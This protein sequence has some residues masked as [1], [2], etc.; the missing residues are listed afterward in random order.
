[1]SI[2]A[3]AHDPSGPL[4]HLPTSW[5]GKAAALMPEVALA[6]LGVLGEVVGLA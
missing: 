2:S 6:Q 5:G 4:G 3:I 1:M